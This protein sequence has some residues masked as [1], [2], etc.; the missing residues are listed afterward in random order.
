MYF[1]RTSE[2]RDAAAG[3]EMQSGMKTEVLIGIAIAGIITILLVTVAIMLRRKYKRARV[4]R[5]RPS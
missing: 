5:E 4:T 3:K 1:V 2:V